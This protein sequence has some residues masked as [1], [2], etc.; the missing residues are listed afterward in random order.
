MRG[1]DFGP[2]IGFFVKNSISQLRRGLKTLA[3][4]QK[5]NFFKKFNFSALHHALSSWVRY[6]F[7]I[8][9]RSLIR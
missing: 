3:A 4:D 8:G 7:G 6:G 5:L 1:I 2:E 9:L